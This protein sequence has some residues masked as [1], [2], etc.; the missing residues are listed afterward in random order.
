MAALPESGSEFQVPSSRGLTTRNLE[1][2]ACSSSSMGDWRG[3][4]IVDCTSGQPGGGN[5]GGAAAAA[6][7]RGG[8]L[9]VWQTGGHVQL[10]TPGRGGLVTVPAHREAVK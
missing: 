5:I 2:E 4:S 7:R 3:S 10:R 6:L 9:E 1:L 8:W